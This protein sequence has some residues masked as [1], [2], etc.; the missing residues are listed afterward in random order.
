MIIKT[1]A[2]LQEAD[3]RSLMF[4]PVGLGGRMRPE[5][6]AEYQQQVIARHEVAPGVAAGTRQSFEQLQEIY[7]Q[8]VLCYPI[9]TMVAEHALLVIEQALRDRFM[10]FH[11]GTVTFIH[12]K[13]GEAIELPVKQYEQ[14]HAFARTNRGYQVRIGDGPEKMP[15]N[16]MLSDL[17]AWARNLRLLRGQRN[18]FIEQA[19][20][21]LRNHVA[22][23][24][25]YNLTTPVDAANTV[26]D[27]AEI[28]NHLWGSPTPGGRLYPEPVDR[29]VVAVAWDDTTRC[30][31]SRPPVGLSFG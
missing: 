4:N 22:H 20:V 15:F 16:G 18:R 27:L 19:L 3:E 23:P 2:E 24:S 8:G 1:L 25:G 14:V 10:D 9:Y 26:S 29:E 17:L 7:A 6:A 30:K 21:R 12:G 13:T 11:Q 28:I 5:D 31:H